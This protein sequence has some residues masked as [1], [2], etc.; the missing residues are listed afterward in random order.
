M[1]IEEKYIARVLLKN[2]V[3]QSDNQSF[4]DLVV[5]ILQ[6]QSKTFTPVKPQG[7]YGDRKNDGFDPCSNTYYQIYGPED[8]P[9]RERDAV[10]KLNEDF[11]GL[12]DYWNKNGFSIERFNYVVNDKYKGAYPELLKAVQCLKSANPEVEIE[13]KRAFHIEDIFMS[14]ND[15]SIIQ[16]VGSIPSPYNISDVDYSILTEVVN[17]ILNFDLPD[18]EEEI[19]I[20]PDFEKKLEFNKIS[21]QTAEIL[22]FAYQQTYVINDFFNTNS[23]FAKDELRDKFEGLYEKAKYIFEDS[24]TISDNIFY[25]IRNESSPVKKLSYY[26]AVYILMAHYFEYCDI[27]E[28]VK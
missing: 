20:N 11:E 2:K 5:N 19:P 25:Y 18:S 13:L 9:K 14:L 15:E 6:L 23:R 26:N 12:K 4:E 24:D 16:T 27:Y 1:N 21:T 17:H 28:S 3:Y 8:L 22:R 10:D 7:R